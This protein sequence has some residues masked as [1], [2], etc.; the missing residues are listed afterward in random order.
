MPGTTTAPPLRLYVPPLSE[1]PLV[2]AFV[3]PD[4]V[5]VPVPELPTDSLLAI[6]HRRAAEVVAA[7]G[8][9]RV[10]EVKGAATDQLFVPPDWVN[11]PEPEKTE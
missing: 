9:P 6:E 3:P 4:W 5:N 11:V 1:N 7:A 8:S 10:A 2:T